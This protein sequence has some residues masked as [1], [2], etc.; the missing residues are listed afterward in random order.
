MK[1][2]TFLQSLLLCSLTGSF[3]VRVTSSRQC[4]KPLSAA[5]DFSKSEK[6][7]DRRDALASL[8]LVPSAALGVTIDA[9]Q[10][11][12]SL[13]SGN[14]YLL[15]S[16]GEALELI[17][18]E[19]DRRFLHGVVASGYM[20][21]YRGM[22]S[23]KSR[24]PMVVQSDTPDEILLTDDFN[25]LEKDM[26]GQPVKPSNSHLAVTSPGSVVNGVAASIWPLGENVHFAWIED[27]GS[28]SRG[29]KIIVDGIDC[30]RMSLED[31]LE[32]RDREVLFRADRFLAVPVALETELL[33][34]LRN[35]FII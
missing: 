9:T 25:S 14:I 7:V 4:L 34:G 11:V 6:T 26:A 1:I 12:P 22:P 17:E 24:F 19:C 28:L 20:L 2:L 21:M 10:H 32:G 18:S 3:S 33:D 16:V 15:G 8:L 29:K 35:A 27:G 13:N 30:G 5:S 23:I 31:A